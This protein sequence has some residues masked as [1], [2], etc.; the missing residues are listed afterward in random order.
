MIGGWRWSMD[1]LRDAYHFVQLIAQQILIFLRGNEKPANRIS[2]SQ[3]FIFHE[4]T[5][6]APAEEDLDHANLKIR[7]V[8]PQPAG[9]VADVVV[10]LAVCGLIFAFMILSANSPKNEM[11]RRIEPT[12]MSYDAEATSCWPRKPTSSRMVVRCHHASC[13]NSVDSRD[14]V[15]T[16]RQRISRPSRSSASAAEPRLSNHKARSDR[17]KCPRACVRT[18]SSRL[19]VQTMPREWLMRRTRSGHVYG[20]YPV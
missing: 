3:D 17:P 9:P 4:F 18:Q 11:A 1:N 14:V 8:A 16:E 20:K 15:V 10:L 6:L 2:L 7:G 19:V 13:D 12:P 5:W